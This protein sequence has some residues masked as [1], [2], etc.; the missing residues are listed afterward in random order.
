MPEIT[1]DKVLKS[2]HRQMG[3]VIAKAMEFLEQM[4]A[5]HQ[6]HPS[7]FDALRKRVISM[8]W[9]SYNVGLWLGKKTEDGIYRS[10][11]RAESS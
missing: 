8:A 4:E 9:D 5:L 7:E 1:Q 2:A 6:L 3:A 10:E 11:Y